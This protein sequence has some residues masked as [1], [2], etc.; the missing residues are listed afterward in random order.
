[1]DNN[2]LHL[3]VKSFDQAFQ[4]RVT[5]AARVADIADKTFNAQQQ[6]QLENSKHCK[7]HRTLTP[8]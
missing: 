2:V 6:V 4:A 8:K 7:T 5:N 1:M 3:W